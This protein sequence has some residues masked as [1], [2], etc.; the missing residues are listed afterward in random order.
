MQS[1]LHGPFNL[2]NAGYKVVK[3]IVSSYI[4]S[5]IYECLLLKFFKHIQ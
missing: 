2:K 4:M 1:T 3:K 5:L